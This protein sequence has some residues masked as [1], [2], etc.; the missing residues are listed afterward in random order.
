MHTLSEALNRSNGVCYA[1]ST[2][3]I[4]LL[5]LFS[6]SHILTFKRLYFMCP[7]FVKKTAFIQEEKKRQPH[8][9]CPLSLSADTFITCKCLH[10]VLFCPFSVAG[11]VP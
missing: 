7:F 6:W 3:V 2:S 10:P 9:S 1:N 11:M 5:F 4:R 8:S